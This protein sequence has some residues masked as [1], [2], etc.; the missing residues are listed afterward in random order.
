MKKIVLSILCTI[1]ASA[2]VG[3]N[4]LLNTTPKEQPKE[5]LKQETKI[6]QVDE[7]IDTEDIAVKDEESQ[8]IKEEKKD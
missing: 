2:I 1:T 6:E 3:A 7:K 8:E 5:Q 4:S